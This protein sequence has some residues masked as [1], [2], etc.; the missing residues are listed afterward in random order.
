[1]NKVTI[2]SNYERKA[3]MLPFVRKAIVSTFHVES[4]Y[5]FLSTQQIVDSPKERE[6]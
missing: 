3:T 6:S 1:M 4:H 5:S 2:L